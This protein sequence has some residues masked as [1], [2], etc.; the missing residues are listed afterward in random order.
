M[1]LPTLLVPAGATLLLLAVFACDSRRDPF[2]ANNRPPVANIWIDPVAGEAP[3]EIQYKA[4]DSFDPDGIIASYNIAFGDGNS[5]QQKSGTHTYTRDG[6]YNLVLTVRDNFGLVDTTM[7]R[8][9][10]ATPPTASLVVTPKQGAFPLRV[11]IDA[12]G[13]NYPF[14]GELTYNI[15]IL[16]QGTQV[17]TPYT[18]SKVT[19]IFT[20]PRDTPYLIRL[21]VAVSGRTDLRAVASEEVMVTNTRPKADF[22]YTP[23]DPQATVQIT[24]TSTSFD[25]DSTDRITNYVWDWGDGSRNSGSDLRSVVHSYNISRT[26]RVKL[27]VTDRFGATGEIEKDIVVR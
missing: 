24:F 6:S 11:T 19:H 2:S 25:P 7:R 26:Y 16:N 3:L 12:S 15:S 8:I 14:G 13:S 4:D 22:T 27:T 5:S 1:K 23:L 20:E 10:V 18:Q 17:G 21:E 9:Q